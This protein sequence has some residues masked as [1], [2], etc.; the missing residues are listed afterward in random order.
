MY[1]DRVAHVQNVSP[2]NVEM[3]RIYTKCDAM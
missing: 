2:K 1:A 3:M